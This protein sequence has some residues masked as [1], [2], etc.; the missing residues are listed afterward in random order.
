VGP[1]F[2]PITFYCASIEEPFIEIYW[3]RIGSHYLWSYPSSAKCSVFRPLDFHALVS[4]SATYPNLSIPL[5]PCFQT[6][7][8]GIFPALPSRPSLLGRVNSLRRLRRRSKIIERPTVLSN[9]AEAI[10]TAQNALLSTCQHVR[11]S[12]AQHR[13]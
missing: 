10:H 8:S 3:S 2:P 13:V 12:L 4:Q 1:R 7:K 6:R 9:H 11:A 5:L